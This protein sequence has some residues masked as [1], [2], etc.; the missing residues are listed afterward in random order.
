MT[1]RTVTADEVAAP[2]WNAEVTRHAAERFAERVLAT[3]FKED[4]AERHLDRAQVMA[5]AIVAFEKG[6]DWESRR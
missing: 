4:S 6:A 2:D 3:M 1:D 5:L